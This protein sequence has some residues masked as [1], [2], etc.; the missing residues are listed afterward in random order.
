VSEDERGTA[1]FDSFTSVLYG[2]FATALF[3]GLVPLAIAITRS[4]KQRVDKIL[5]IYIDIFA[6]SAAAII[7]AL[8][9]FRPND[10]AIVAP[11]IGDPDAKQLA[12]P[13]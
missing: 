7:A 8:R 5:D 10:A 4:D 11:E 13:D 12:P 9:I 1:M 6:A 2:A 3:F